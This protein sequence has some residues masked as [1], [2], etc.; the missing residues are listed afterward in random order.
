MKTEQ[1]IFEEYRLLN[2]KII[3]HENR[4]FIM[5]LASILCFICILA[6]SDS[7]HPLILPYV[8]SMIL[9]A[10]SIITRIQTNSQNAVSIYMYE[11]I[12]PLLGD[13]PFERYNMLEIHRYRKKSLFYTAKSLISKIN[14]PLFL[15]FLTA[16]VMSIYFSYDFIREFI[17]SNELVFVF[18]YIFLLI[19]L[20]IIFFIN[21]YLSNSAVLFKKKTTSS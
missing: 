10:T 2:R 8:F 6:Y 16:F 20:Q 3:S 4:R 13:M 11:K 18:A 5:V 7:I 17:L 15:M 14:N 21:I 19:F 9:V 1:F 12:G